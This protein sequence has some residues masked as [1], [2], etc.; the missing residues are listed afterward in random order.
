MR[1][2]IRNSLI[3]IS[4]I[5]IIGCSTDDVDAPIVEEVKDKPVAV[6][7]EAFAFPG[8]EGF[9]KYTTGGRGGKVIYVTNLNDSGTGSFRSAVQTSGK[10]IILFKVSGNIELR[11]NVSITNN[12]ITI[13][14]QTA[15]GD[16]I[17]LKNY[18]LIV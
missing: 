12:D 8:A 16:G 11:S 10:R 15:P 4:L 7:E 6:E 3:I 18:S 13:A 5:F 17:T 9:G 2:F 1:S 14:G